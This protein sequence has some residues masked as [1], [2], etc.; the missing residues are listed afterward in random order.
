MHVC[1]KTDRQSRDTVE[2][3][4]RR[5]GGIGTQHKCY[6]DPSD[7]S[8]GAVFNRSYEWF[9]VFNIFFWPGLG[10]I[11]GICICAGVCYLRRKKVNFVPE[12]PNEENPESSSNSKRPEM[13]TGSQL[14]FMERY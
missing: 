13:I 11:T 9:L 3:F 2:M 14:C 10:F 7:I 12:R 4:R 1:K 6:Y 8:R 5:Y